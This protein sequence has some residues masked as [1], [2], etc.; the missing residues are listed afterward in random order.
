MDTKTKIAL[1]CV[2]GLGLLSIALL[3]IF[4]SG[5]FPQWF[6]GR[7]DLFRLTSVKQYEEVVDKPYHPD[8]SVHTAPLDSGIVWWLGDSFSRVQFGHK[9][10]PEEVSDKLSAAGIGKVSAVDTLTCRAPRNRSL[11]LPP[12]ARRKGSPLRKSSWWN[13]SNATCM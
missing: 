12:P 10:L 2:R 1:W 8:E 6:T 11:R 9:P 7:G 3:V 4:F 13:V 5:A